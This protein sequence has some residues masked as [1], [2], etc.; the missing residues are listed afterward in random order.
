[1]SFLDLQVL[2]CLV[3][4]FWLARKFY[5]LLM[6]SLRTA[7]RRWLVVPLVIALSPGMLLGLAMLG[8]NRPFSDFTDLGVMPWSVVF[9][10]GMVLPAALTVAAASAPLWYDKPLADS[11]RWRWTTIVIGLAF[12]LGFHAWDAGNYRKGGFGAYA[13][14]ISKGWHDLAI[15]SILVAVIVWV[16]RL[17][18][19][20]GKLWHKL[21]FAGLLLA[22]LVL[23]GFDT[24][25][26]LDPAKMHGACDTVCAAPNLAAHLSDAM[27]WLLSL[28]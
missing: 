6:T 23:M 22:Q 11:L 9:G 28:V 4:L 14:A 3:A 16:A 1:M 2:A 26:G 8:E 27:Y 18:L 7:G 17:V 15:Y 10:D 13:D 20:Y 19:T 24:V 21:A 12:G 25:R 5:R